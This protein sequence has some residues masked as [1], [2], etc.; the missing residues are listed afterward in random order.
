MISLTVYN[1]SRISQS[2]QTESKLI[3]PR[4]WKEGRM[5]VTA[6]RYEISSGM[7][8]IC[9]PYIMAMVAQLHKYTKSH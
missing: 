3:V 9:Y 8:E 4:G 6:N 1:L 2:V 5:G 7:I